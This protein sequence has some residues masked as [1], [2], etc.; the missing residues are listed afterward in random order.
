M[1][2]H[3]SWRRHSSVRSVRSETLRC[4]F[5]VHHVRRR[6]EVSDPRLRWHEKDYRAH[7]VTE[8]GR[9]LG[10]D[11]TGAT[12]NKGDWS[13]GAPEPGY[14]ES[15][16]EPGHPDKGWCK[17][18]FRDLNA[19]GGAWSVAWAPMP[20]HSDAPRSGCQAKAV[21]QFVGMIPAGCISW[22]PWTGGAAGAGRR[23]AGVPRERGVPLPAL[24]RRIMRHA[25]IDRVWTLW[26]A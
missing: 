19:S 26:R 7:R 9:G 13:S 1:R 11:L 21:C 20:S 25:R 18:K 23:S 3:R 8:C 16:A 12:A 6:S 24:E 10:G 17:N 2:E 15:P 14:R 22:K 5:G 4:L